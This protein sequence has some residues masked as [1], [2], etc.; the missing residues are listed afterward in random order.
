MLTYFVLPCPECA[1]VL[2]A[3]TFDDLDHGRD[4]FFR[5]DDTFYVPSKVNIRHI[6]AYTVITYLF[7]RALLQL[8][9]RLHQDAVRE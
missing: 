6:A 9:S 8:T 5:T 3:L 4:R 7:R 2:Y 1:A